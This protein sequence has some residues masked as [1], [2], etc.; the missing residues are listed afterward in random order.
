M[1]TW[2]WICVVFGGLAFLGAVLKG[3]NPTGPVFWLGLGVFLLYRAN[4]KKQEQKEKDKWSK[5]SD[6]HNVKVNND[7]ENVK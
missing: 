4:Q 5:G 3:N 2:G 6:V 7:N 1:K